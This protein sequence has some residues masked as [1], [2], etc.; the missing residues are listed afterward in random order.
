MD[1]HHPL[2]MGKVHLRHHA[3]SVRHLLK[4]SGLRM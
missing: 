3:P 2:G 1:I 4:W